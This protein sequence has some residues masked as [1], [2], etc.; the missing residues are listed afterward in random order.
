MEWALITRL[1]YEIITYLVLFFCQQL[2]VFTFFFKRKRQR[3][4][5]LRSGNVDLMR[6][7]SLQTLFVRVL[8]PF[9]VSFEEFCKM[10]WC[11]YR[12]CFFILKI[13]MVKYECVTASRLCGNY[14][15]SQ[16]RRRLPRWSFVAS[17][18]Y[19]RPRELEFDSQI[20]CTL[21][22]EVWIWVHFMT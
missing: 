12:I 2:R 5:L 22:P 21:F 11:G 3:L 18:R 9:R 6:T 15:T 16:Y 4:W 20:T 19:C 7:V 13:V 14:L 17:T 10:M 8:T 1:A